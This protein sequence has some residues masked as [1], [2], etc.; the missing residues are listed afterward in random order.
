MARCALRVFMLASE[1]APSTCT[2]SVLPAIDECV[3][4]TTNAIALRAIAERLI[5][6]QVAMLDWAQPLSGQQVAAAPAPY[7]SQWTS[8]S[9]IFLWPKLEKG[10]LRLTCASIA[11]GPF[12]A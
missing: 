5:M 7:V 3:R 12:L 2:S 9:P 8:Y 1:P 11:T 4:S 6:L 10:V